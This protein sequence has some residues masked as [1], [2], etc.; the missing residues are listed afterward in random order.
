MITSS[1]IKPSASA[2]KTKSR[3]QSCEEREGRARNYQE[4]RS[5]SPTYH[6]EIWVGEPT[7]RGY[8]INNVGNFFGSPGTDWQKQMAVMIST[9]GLAEM[10]CVKVT[11]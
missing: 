5:D 6:R 8:T 4:V 9:Q 1:D 3:P 2:G 7:S 10:Q 11:E